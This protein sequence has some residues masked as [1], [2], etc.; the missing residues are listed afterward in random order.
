MGPEG[1]ELV[2]VDTEVE[3]T[4]KHRDVSLGLRDH[5]SKVENEEQ[6]TWGLPGTCTELPDHGEHPS[7]QPT[8]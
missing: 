3:N 7:P 8:A 2:P 5:R 1:G 4:T 6:F